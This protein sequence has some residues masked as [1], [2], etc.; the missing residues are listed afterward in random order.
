MKKFSPYILILL[1]LLGLFSPINKINAAGACWRTDQNVPMVVANR[2]VS[3]DDCMRI[4]AAPAAQCTWIESNQPSSPTTPTNPAPTTPTSP[5]PTNPASPTPTTTEDPLSDYILLAPIPCP[6]GVTEGCENGKLTSFNLE[7]EN[8]LSKY[9]NIMIKII[10]GLCA[11]M[12]V[13]MIVV[14]GME[15]MTSELMHSK[16]EGK[17]RMTEAIFGL[18]VALGAW[19]LLN[20]INPKLLDSKLSS[21]DNVTLAVDIEADV[22]QTP[23][24]GRYPNG[25]TVG[26][27]WDDTVG[28]N[29]ALPPRIS[30]KTPPC[31]TVGQRDCTSIRNLNIS[32]VRSIQEGCRCDILI[33][34][35]TESWLHGGRTGNTSHQLGSG[36]VDLRP[37]EELNRYLS[38]GKPLVRMQRYPGPG[39]PYL[40]EGN[41]WHI[42]R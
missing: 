41:H 35:G 36:T 15:Y 24:N 22:P 17:H 30:A 28:T 29:P 7:D 37:S 6:A 34:G 40:Y 20:T 19:A 4:C 1:V 33:T 39:G 21:I 16:E 14:G 32:T 9:L 18:I 8:V 23:V 25:V 5:A 3:K 2:A 10:I 26:N 13:I 38:G 42:G 11:V 31:T 27:R 12:A